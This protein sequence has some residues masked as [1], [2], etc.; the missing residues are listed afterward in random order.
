RAATTHAHVLT[1]TATPIPR[2]YDMAAAG[3][4][5]ISALRTPPARR[6][7][8]RTRVAPFDADVIAGALREEKARGGQSFVVCPRVADMPAMQELLARAAPELDLRAAHGKMA[9]DAL[10][11][12][13]L[14]FA[15]GEGDVLLATNIIESG[16]DLPRANTM[17]VTRPD[18]FGL[19]QLHQLRGRVGRGRRRGVTLF[20]TDP[21]AELT[22]AARK[23]LETLERLH[24]LGAGA[25]ISAQDRDARGGGDL[26]GDRQAGHVSLVGP[27]LHRRLLEGALARA[28]GE[29]EEA[30]APALAFA[31]PALVPA[32]YAPDPDLRLGLYARL[33][34][35][36]EQVEIDAF[37]EELEERFGAPPQPVLTL[38][39]QARLA[40]CCRALGVRAVAAGPKAIAFDL[41]PGADKA[42]FA[43]NEALRLKDDRLLAD[44]ADATAADALRLLS[45]G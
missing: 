34:R 30:P 3:L 6:L 38:I 11:A 19:S 4:R 13:M 21:D 14:A 44:V 39:D 18:L 8:S 20:L 24:D 23:R 35:L 40:L 16:L 2:T 41:A 25:A 15:R 26:T 22:D 10:D 42:A 31:A 9:P 27:A 33:A 36:R 29:P 17:V 12:T 32:D 7:P 1:M 5:T 45:G 37:V 28:R 43:S